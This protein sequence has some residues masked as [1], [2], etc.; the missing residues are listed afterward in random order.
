M[1][2]SDEEEKTI[3]TT[4]IVCNSLSFIGCFFILLMYLFFKELR[5][6]SFRLVQY[7]SII[8]LF[9]SI[10]LMLP[11]DESNWW[12]I[13]QASSLQ[14]T[15]LSSIVW[16][17]IIAYALYDSVINQNSKVEL[18][19]I[20]FIL[21]GYLSPI[22]TAIPPFFTNSYGKAE[23]WCW[24]RIREDHYTIDVTWRFMLFYI[25]I[26]IIFIISIIIYYRIIK[27]VNKQFKGVADSSEFNLK[28]ALIRRLI[29]YPLITF[30]CYL[31]VTVRRIYD[32]FDPR[33]SYF[34]LAESSAIM[35][36]L[37]GFFNAFVY[38]FTSSVRYAIKQAWASR[39]K[40]SIDSRNSQSLSQYP[41]YTGF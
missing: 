36:S 31:L 23:G 21:V 18:N 16:S 2:L 3:N 15:A 28:K 7:M 24:M 11:W 32:F 27:Y 35:I 38:G 39:K 34:P 14:Y 6:F 13:I 5:S 12:C 41:H 10:T 37:T 33:E 19:E 30:F 9:H 25:P 29:L 26:W 22:L 20:K 1:V 17:L 8:D 4:L 40:D